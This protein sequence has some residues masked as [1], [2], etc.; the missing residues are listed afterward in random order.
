M[1]T[2]R[3]ILFA[4]SCREHDD[5]YVIDIKF[6]VFCE[7]LIQNLTW[8]LSTI[9]FLLIVLFNIT[10]DSSHIPNNEHS[11]VFNLYPFKPPNYS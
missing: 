9:H 4:N 8:M 11:T 2:A 6:S 3:A 1:I 7:T 10:K 5:H